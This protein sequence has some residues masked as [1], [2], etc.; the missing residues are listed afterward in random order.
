MEFDGTPA[1]THANVSK[2]AE[3]ISLG[4]GCFLKI[5]RYKGW[6]ILWFYIS[7]GFALFC[8]LDL[9]INNGISLHSKGLHG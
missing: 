2:I 1:H 5:N 4:I 7:T 9:P 3:R 6:A 8:S